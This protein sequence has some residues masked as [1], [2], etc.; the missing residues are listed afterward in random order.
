MVT[1][2]SPYRKHLL[3]TVACVSLLMPTAVALAPLA[4]N[5]TH[6]FSSWLSASHDPVDDAP[7][8]GVLP[9]VLSTKDIALYQD[10]NRLQKMANW[11][12]A[13]TI[14][15][16]LN[17]DLLVG[18]V[19]AARY[20]DTRY[21]PSNTELTAW[22]ER[23]S[24]H[25]EAGD[26][27]SLATAQ[28]SVLKGQLPII[29]KSTPLT[30]AGDDAGGTRA[31][32]DNAPYS[33]TWHDAME[34]WKVGNKAEAANLFAV[35][36]HYDLS[37]WM[38]AEANFWAYRAFDAIGDDKRA[39]RYLVQAA[40]VKRSFYGILAC[41][42]LGKSLGLDTTPMALN[43]DD[44]LAMVGD[45]SVRRIIALTQ[46]GQT[47]LA[48]KELR[49]RFP[50]SDEDEKPRLLALAHELGLA[51]VQI[52]MAGRMRSPE[53][54]LD[55]ARYP[56]P[57]WQPEDG[58]TIDPMLIYALMR[59]ESGFKPS[60]VSK[61]GALGL[62]QIMP[63][64]ASFMQRKN[65]AYAGNI[66]EPVTNITLGQDY[67]E[68]LLTNPLVDGNLLYLL[69]AY[70]AGPGHLQEWT[71]NVGN[72]HD[73][74]LFIESIPFAQTRHYVMQVMTNYWIYAELGGS[75]TPSAYALLNGQFPTYVP[76]SAEIAA[77]TSAAADHGA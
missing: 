20:L 34:A 11:A 49:Q 12:A 61:D 5:A 70:N 25:P 55:F 44:L 73:P 63:K 13:D 54:E 39:H 40:S 31:N 77:R 37:P 48:E 59:Q 42:K 52:S 26:L 28:S 19:L 58:F 65:G 62:M 24:D 53:H 17:N 46:S 68:H 41:K 1:T 50:A 22:F 29:S 38:K 21:H 27:Y 66:T 14:I 2:L 10:I 56:V 47:E 32:D 74:L 30:G 4:G 57:G 76:H 72:T 15:H 33:R 16:Q 71:K 45:Q 36:L 7:S 8:H 3:I 69:A 60:A 18:H 67:V 51:S 23:Y 43:D 9:R 35:V 6:V 75:K 64:T